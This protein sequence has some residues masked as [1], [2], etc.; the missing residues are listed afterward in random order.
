[1]VKESSNTKEKENSLKTIITN[2]TFSDGTAVGVTEEF[3]QKCGEKH[4]YV[5]KIFKNNL[6][7]KE[8]GISRL[9]FLSILK[10]SDEDLTSQQLEEIKTSQQQEKIKTKK[11][12]AND[13]FR[14][15]TAAK[16]FG[17]KTLAD[18]YELRFVKA[19]CSM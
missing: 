15:K 19:E 6:V 3:L 4:D 5:L 14:L 18:C 13:Y 1:M 17:L 9:D 2:T 7:E 10:D 8:I 16:K 12:V 11:V